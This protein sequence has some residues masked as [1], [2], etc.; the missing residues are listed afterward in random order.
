MA[1]TVT[2]IA[3]ILAIILIFFKFTVRYDINSLDQTITVIIS[4]ET[5]RKD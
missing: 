4:M 2:V 3:M 1:M 5:A